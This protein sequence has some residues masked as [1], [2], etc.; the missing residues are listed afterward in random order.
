MASKQHSPSVLM[1]PWLAHGHISPFLELAKRLA[2]RNFHIYLCST[3]INLKPI[4]KTLLSGQLF[5]SIQLIDIHLPS[6]P[7]LP[8]HFHTTKDLPPH[9]MSDLKTAFDAAKPDFC[10]IL[11]TFKPNLVIY[12]FVQPWAPEVAREENIDAVLFLTFGASTCAFLNHFFEN[13]ALEYP[14]PA[15]QFP[16]MER[17]KI[18]GFMYEISN[19]VSSKERYLGCLASSSSI[20][21]I[22]T[23][24]EIEEKY[25]D[26]LSVLTGKEM[27]TV[28]HLLQDPT[29]KDE[30]TVIM[31]WLSKQEASSVVFVAFGSEYFL[32]K[33]EIKEI[34][35]G[36]ELS[37]VSFIWVVRFHGGESIRLD[38]ALPEGFQERVGKRGM[39]LEGWAPQAKILGHTGIGG[40]VSHCG[41][42]STLEGVMFG[43]PIIAMPMH[44]DQP[45]NAKVVVEIGI[46]MEVKK[47][48]GRFN[49][50][51]VAKVINEVVVEEEG[52]EVRRKV[53]EL[54]ESM[55]EKGDEEVDLAVKKLVQLV[56]EA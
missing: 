53:K 8:P 26:Y 27:V 2:E 31:E 19:G 48:N 34:A 21:L 43:V 37:K 45:L 22:K 49:R 25:I 20:V 46:G 3:P 38:E 11:R 55:R 16:G 42:S 32:S 10:N 51:E 12:D 41:W 14:F 30:D 29:N 36:L 15:F 23:S 24:I 56:R 40:F 1:L 28:G 18:I 13:P 17:Q 33:E 35:Y 9:L 47:E 50:E 4:R 6:S 44:L 7:E 52:R 39:V 5:P 54:R